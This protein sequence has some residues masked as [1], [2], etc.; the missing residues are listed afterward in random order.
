MS[1][2]EDF[3]WCHQLY[4]SQESNIRKIP[5]NSGS[6][7]PSLGSAGVCGKVNY[8]PQF[9]NLSCVHA[10]CRGTLQV[11]PLWVEG[12]SLPLFSALRH[13]MHFD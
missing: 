12:T 6:G 7:I 10:L 3:V 8:L 9:S 5:P 4:K 2:V 11:L 13:L 1:W